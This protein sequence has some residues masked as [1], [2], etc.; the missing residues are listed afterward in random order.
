MNAI[1]AF[2]TAVPWWMLLFIFFAKLL[3]VSISTVRVILVQRGFK[4]LGAILSFFEVLIWVFVAA[5]VIDDV[6]TFPLKGIT[7]ALGF[8]S[9]VVLG[10]TIEKKL[11]FGK[12][13]LQVIAIPEKATEIVHLV[14][15]RKIGVTS[16][17]GKGFNTERTIL[18]IFVERR[19]APEL[20]SNIKEIDNQA[21]VGVSDIN[22]VYGGFLPRRYSLLRK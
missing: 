19:H 1:I 10:S 16:I 4:I 7:Y 12:V 14:H 8:A 22:N 11:A 21:M 17:K 20:I 15:E 18:M 6:S 13:L 3:E 2:F 5:N 9:G